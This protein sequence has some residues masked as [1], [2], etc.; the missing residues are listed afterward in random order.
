MQNIL[1]ISKD[2]LY[3]YNHEFLDYISKT[4]DDILFLTFKRI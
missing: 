2:I 4:N 1:Q 3:K